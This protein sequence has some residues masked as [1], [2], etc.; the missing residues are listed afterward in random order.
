MN[1]AILNCRR[2]F[3]SLGFAHSQVVRIWNIFRTRGF[4]RPAGERWGGGGR[5][6]A[7]P[8]FRPPPPEATAAPRHPSLPLTRSQE[9]GK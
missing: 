8:D 7:A 5:R 9:L 2:V 4:I 6:L 1:E 3:L